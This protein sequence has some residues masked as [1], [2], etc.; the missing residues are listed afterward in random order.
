MSVT[1]E[2]IE[3]LAALAR[4]EL[5]NAEKEKLREDVSAILE[6]VSQI[7]SVPPQPARPQTNEERTRTGADGIDTG[8]MYNVMREDAIPHESGIYTDA[9]LAA[10]PERDEEY[11]KVK[12]IL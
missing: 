1:I 6:Y 4:I 8:G 3:K 11:I 9:L 2:E 7:Q 10:A 12:K 5:S